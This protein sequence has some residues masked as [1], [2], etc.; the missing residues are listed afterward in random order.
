MEWLLAPVAVDDFLH[1]YW[2]TAPLL[3]DREEPGHLSVLPGLDDLDELITTTTS[4]RA[5]SI[6][7]GRLVRTDPDGAVSSRELPLDGEGIP[8]IHDIYRA[9]YGGY[10]LVLNRLHRRSRAVSLLCRAIEA[11]LH[12]PVGANL[13][14]TPRTGQGFRPTSTPMTSLSCSCT[15]SRSGMSPTLLARSRLTRISIN[16]MPCLQAFGLSP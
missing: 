10:T 9:Y 15:G 11:A 14:L 3:I 4:G 6:N 12:H 2:E 16:F 1:T 7:D 13:Y 8:D 5:R